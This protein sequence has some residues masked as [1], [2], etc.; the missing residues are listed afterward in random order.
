MTTTDAALSAGTRVAG[1]VFDLD[2]TL[3]D[4]APDITS[5]VN[6]MLATRGLPPQEVRF[7]EQFIGEGSY[8]LIDK[9]YKGLG[10]TLD[11][12]RVAADVETYLMLYKQ[13]PVEHSTVYQDALHAIPALHAGGVALG[14][15]TNKAQFLAEAVLK[16]FNLERYF[17]S[18]IG[19]DA[20][21]ERKPHPRH[22]L[23]TLERMNVAPDQALYIG[24]TT[25]DA[26]CARDANVRCFI[27]NW[28]TGP[29]VDVPASS[30]LG[31]FADL[32]GFSAAPVEAILR[33]PDEK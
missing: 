2:G 15:C 12:A 31:A 33:E 7:V 32:L 23:V 9:L 10:L 22:L 20:L 19:G 16:H 21:P 29:A 17:T 5:A 24:D 26:Q 18:I 27:V 30:R 6:R 8:G 13:H 14:V 28:G 4:T 1:I 25:I 3:V 11:Q